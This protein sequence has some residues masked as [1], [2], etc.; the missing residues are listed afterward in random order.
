[1]QRVAS[2]LLFRKKKSKSALLFA[3]RVQHFRRDAKLKVT[4]KFPGKI[5]K[6]Q[7]KKTLIA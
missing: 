1:M 3:P 5:D 2:A 7:R 4:W 6:N